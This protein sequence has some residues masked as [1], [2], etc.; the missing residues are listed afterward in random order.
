MTPTV[1][2]GKF[3]KAEVY[4]H[5]LEPEA[6]QQIR[7]FLDH[8]AFAHGRIAIMPDV[9]AGKGAVIGFTATLGDMVIPN[10]IGV[11]IGCGVRAWKLGERAVDFEALDRFIRARIPSGREV[12]RNVYELLEAAH[13]RIPDIRMRDGHERFMKRLAKAVKT[14]AQDHDRVVS[15]IGSLGGGNHFIEIDRD[16]TGSLWLTIHSGSRNFGLRIAE[17]YQAAARKR[18]GSRGGLE[19][20]TGSE[21]DAYIEDMK[22]AQE[23]AALN[24]SVMGS[25]ILTDHFGMRADTETIESVH[26]YI[27]FADNIIRKGA[28]SAHKDE[29]VIIPF[30]MRDGI[31]LGRGKGVKA[32]NLSAPHGAGRTMSR[33][34]A[35]SELKMDDF[36]DSM[37]G[38]WTS[39]V[40]KD[41]IDESP[42]AYKPLDAIMNALGDTV[43]TDARLFPVYNFKAKD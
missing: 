27:S 19:Y 43:S 32:W 40:N 4:A 18:T 34:R 30:N 33:S 38:I 12:R 22:T 41:T 25:I 17:F 13:E 11:D 36:R 10:V 31:L 23:Y 15:S 7:T 16:E 14:T 28:I 24:R 1:I 26:N 3:N 37:K 21:R 39:S 5:E 20:L 29:R 42:M 6:A 9:H 35:K 8:E 2:T